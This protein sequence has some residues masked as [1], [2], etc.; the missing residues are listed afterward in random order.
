[1][2][3]VIKCKRLY[4][5]LSAHLPSLRLSWTM[6]LQLPVLNLPT[7]ILMNHPLSASQRRIYLSGKC[8]EIEVTS[9]VW[10][11]RVEGYSAG[12]SSLK[13]FPYVQLSHL[14]VYPERRDLVNFPGKIIN[15]VELGI[16]RYLRDP[17][18]TF[19]N[20]MSSY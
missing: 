11:D 5:E 4:R 15:L 20:L 2:E 7:Q 18:H 16:K 9:I 8:T 13:F 17:N 3:V 19:C 1:M 12:L 6:M 14:Q 10:P